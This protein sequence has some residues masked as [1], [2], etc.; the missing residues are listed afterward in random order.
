[1]TTSAG[2]LINGC[3][4]LIGMLAEGESPSADT[5]NDALT[6]MQ[7]MIDSW[8]TERLSV[9]TTQEQVFTWPANQRLRTLGPTGDFVGNRPAG[10]LDDATYYKTN[11]ISYNV[12][13]INQQLYN[14]IALKTATTTLPNLL[15]MNA[16]YPNAELY[17]YP[18]PTQ[19]LEFYFV[20]IQELTQ[21]V[22]LATT[23]AFPP[24]YLRA[25]RFNLACEFGPEFGEAVP[26]D[27]KRIAVMSK[28][29]IKRIN[30]PGDVMSFDNNLIGA[31]GSRFNSY[32]GEPF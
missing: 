22:V 6:A 5:S 23:L 14:S 4:R 2:D 1:M 12:Q 25:F 27:V 30:D 29:T 17:L 11:N 8:S 19:A 28:R 21:P 3:L 32:S 13:L 16:S 20:S 15:Y 10:E 26:A 9:F 24:G 18:V 7:Q 31:G